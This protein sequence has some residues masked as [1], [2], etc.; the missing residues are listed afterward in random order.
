MA[1]NLPR[2]PRTPLA[3]LRPTDTAPDLLVDRESE[4]DELLF[5]LEDAF[6]AAQP[7]VRILVTGERG[8]GKSILARWVVTEFA[9][10]HPT[11]V[12]AVELEGRSLVYRTLLERLAQQLALAARDLLREGDSYHSSLDLLDALGRH[13]QLS[14][15]QVNGIARKYG[16]GAGA[17]GNALLAKLSGNFTW[18]HT[19]SAGQ[20]VSRVAQV[21]D[22]LLHDAITR[23]LVDLGERDKCVVILFD[24]L[25]QAST[26]AEAD[27]VSELVQRILGLRPCLSVVHLRSEALL[28]NVRREI[29]QTLE[30]HALP[31]DNMLDMLDRR[32]DLWKQATREGEAPRELDLAQATQAF[33]R[34]AGAVQNPLVFL[35]W[36]NALLRQHGLPLP[37]DWS[38]EQQLH[39]AS[40]AHPVGVEGALIAKLLRIVDRCALEPDHRWCRR[41]DLL[42]GHR[43]LD[44]KPAGETLTDSELELLIDRQ[45]VLLPRNRFEQPQLYR[46]DP[47]LD[48]L[49]ASVR[50]RLDG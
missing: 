11:D 21:T 8:S 49:R 24:D 16:V 6:G 39:A 47:V 35:R 44:P 42:V 40:T 3:W 1:T 29:D 33:R 18:E 13:S 20:T 22:S 14:D 7:D 23:V 45:Q 17:E 32:L 48:L 30:V 5:W 27:A 12:A 43:P 41:E 26:A 46:V 25:D 31:D 10:A 50:Q 34:L 15:S 9:Q 28:D 2:P 36:V 38:A 37:P 4:R 19:V